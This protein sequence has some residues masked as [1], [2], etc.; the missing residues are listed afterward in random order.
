MQI[1]MYEVKCREEEGA[2]VEAGPVVEGLER[3][4]DEIRS[5]EEDILRQI[6]QCKA[7]ENSVTPVE[8]YLWKK[9]QRISTYD[10][11]VAALCADIEQQRNQ[12]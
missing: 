12:L 11:S 6:Q 4:V 7:V 1:A 8:Y 2:R 3:E 10:V 5:E 9:K